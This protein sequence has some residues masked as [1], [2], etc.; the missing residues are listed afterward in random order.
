V[1][2]NLA[3]DTRR[4]RPAHRLHC[5]RLDQW[6]RRERMRQLADFP[7][8]LRSSPMQAR[9]TRQGEVGFQ[10]VD[11]ALHTE[12]WRGRLVNIF[13]ELEPSTSRRTLPKCSCTHGLSLQPLIFFRAPLC[14][15]TSCKTFGGK[16]KDCLKP[17]EDICYGSLGICA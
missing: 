3:F 12:Q 6:L 16:C 5:A 8:H 10:R 13:A 11:G 4:G 2:V 9:H 15:F 1:F 14:L 17:V 7:A